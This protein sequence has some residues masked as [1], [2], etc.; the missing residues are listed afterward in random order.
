MLVGFLLAADWA[1]VI[2]INKRMLAFVHPLPLN[3]LLRLVTIVG[4]LCMTVPLTAF[5][6]WD[7]ELR[8]DAG[9]G[10]VHRRLGGRH[11]DRRLQRLLLRTSRRAGH[12]WS[13]RSLATDPIW[14]ALF[15]PIL[16]GTVLDPLVVV[17]LVVAT[18]ASCS[19]RAG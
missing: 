14:A 18:A 4:L 6:W 3:L 16:L 15:S 12:R 1:L 13:L 5:E 2:V 7:L 9:G 8:P 11:L 17:G 10:R 19:S